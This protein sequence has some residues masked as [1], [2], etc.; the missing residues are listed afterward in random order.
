MYDLTSPQPLVDI[1]FSGA[2]HLY[3]LSLGG[4]ISLWDVRMRDIVYSFSDDGN[5]KPSVL[6][7]S[8]SGKHLATGSYT[9]IVNLYQTNSLGEGSKPAQQF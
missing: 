7:V 9:G 5:Y 8:P 3:T 1:A 6:K 4:E 2:N